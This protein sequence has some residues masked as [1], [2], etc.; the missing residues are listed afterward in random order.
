MRTEERYVYHADWEPEPHPYGAGGENIIGLGLVVPGSGAAIVDGAIPVRGVPI[1][2][3]IVDVNPPQACPAWGCGRPPALPPMYFNYPG[4][5]SVVPQPPP[6]SGPASLTTT[7]IASPPVSPQPSPTV[8]VSPDQTAPQLTAPG[9]V[10]DS[11]GASVSVAGGIGTWLAQSSL[12]SGFPNWGI[13]A[14]AVAAL[15]LF[16]GGKS[17]RR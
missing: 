12:I 15:V 6:P 14:A 13:A 7:P 1:R 11:S 16:S 5:T 10:L 8:A 2:S 4:A 17:G 3:P 9:T